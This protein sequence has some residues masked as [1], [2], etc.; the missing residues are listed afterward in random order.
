MGIFKFKKQIEPATP[1]TDYSTLFIDINTGKLSQKKSDGS[2][3]VFENEVTDGDKGDITVSGDG[4][5]WSINL[6]A[7]TFA[8]MQN[9][10]TGKIIGRKTAG[11]G[12][13]EEITYSELKSLL[14]LN[15]VDNTPDID[16]PVSTATQTELDEKEDSFNKNTAFNKDFGT[17]ANDVMQGNDQ[18]VIDNVAKVGI[19]TQQALDISNNNQKVSDI[20]HV[21]DLLPNVDNTS[22]EDKP[23]STATQTAFDNIVIPIPVKIA[24]TGSI[25]NLGNTGGNICNMA[26][27][28]GE[29][30]YT[31]TGSV[32]FG[33]S[34]ILIN[35]ATA[36]V[37]T[38]ATSILGSDFIAN[39]DMYLNVFNNGTRVE[40]WLAQI[41]E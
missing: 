21:Q 27:A 38:G 6:G 16:K 25:I 39:T 24:D 28:N 35:R 12:S 20:N 23:I 13:A 5:A 10:A 31:L 9:I 2:I 22:D 1:A 36:P 7:V 32:D 34:Q 4:G 29:E 40:Y 15:D 30:T 19:T 18:R 33:V 8:K 41:A 3:V 14:D 37:V 26:S 17:D 11:S